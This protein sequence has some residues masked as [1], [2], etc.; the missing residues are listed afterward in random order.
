MQVV[1]EY[2]DGMFSWVDLTTTAAQAAKPFYSELFGW[3]VEERPI[4]HGGVYLMMKIDGKNVA[5]MGDM[6]PEMKEQGMPSV[7]TSYIKHDDVDGVAKKIAEAGGTPMGEPMDVME[8]GRMLWAQD[9]PGAS[10]GVWQPKNHIGAE[11]VNRPNT[12]IWNELQTRDKAGAEAI[13]SAVFGWSSSSD[14]TGYGMFAIGDRVQA[15][16]L[17]MDES[18][19]PIPPIWSVYFMVEDVDAAVE[20]AKTLGAAVHVPPT[21]AGEMGKFSTLA[22]PTGA[23]FV[24]MQFNGEVDAP[25]GL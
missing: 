20:K 25:P 15:G 4:P 23:V 2:P 19:G 5:G 13:Y 1:T 22:D 14:E 3:E 12:L 8:E 6:P 11:L 9:P 18:F 7:W 16:V 17:A 10:F 24:V 21:S